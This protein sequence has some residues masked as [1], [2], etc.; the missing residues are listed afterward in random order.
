MKK[1]NDFFEELRNYETRRAD[2]SLSL[3]VIRFFICTII[4]FYFIII[5][6][7]GWI[8]ADISAILFCVFILLATHKPTKETEF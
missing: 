1:N 5:A 7:C 2:K 8:P 6:I 3:I 4:A